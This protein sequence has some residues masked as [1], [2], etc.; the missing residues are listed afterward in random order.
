[1]TLKTTFFAAAA[2]VALMAAPAALAQDMDAPATSPP[3]VG[4][5]VEAA[6]FTDAQVDGFADAMTD[7]QALNDQY[8]PRVA[9]EA[10]TTARAALQ[11]QMTTEMTA[12]VE[13]A[14]LTA[15]EYNQIAAAAQGDAELRARIGQ[16]M[17]ADAGASAD[18]AAQAEAAPEAEGDVGAEAE[19]DAQADPV[20]DM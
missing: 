11:Q 16:S 4:A 9:G 8:G 12:A 10:D 20:S 18:A 15:E 6:T 5:P 17:Q 13:A 3:A 14:G 19:V 7:I 1:M 2:T